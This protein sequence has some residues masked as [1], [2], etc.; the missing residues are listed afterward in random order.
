[1]K[2]WNFKISGGSILEDVP[3][4]YSDELISSPLKD[5][6]QAINDEIAASESI[7]YAYFTFLN[8]KVEE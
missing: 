7:R 4:L 3:K 5:Q 6:I 1:M 2:E 8:L